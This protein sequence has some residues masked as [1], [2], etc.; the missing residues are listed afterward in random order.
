MLLSISKQP[1]ISKYSQLCHLT[2]FSFAQVFPLISKNCSDD[3]QWELLYTSL[4]LMPLGLLKCVIPWY[5]AHLSV[6][7]SRS[8]LHF[9][10]Q[11][12]DNFANTSF[13]SLLLEWFHIGYS[14]KSSGDI[15][16]DLQKIFKSRC[17]FLCE[18][19]KETAGCSSLHPN[20]QPCGESKSSKTELIP[21]NKGKKL[22]S[23]TSSG[24][25]KAETYETLYASEI[26]LH[27]FF[28][29]TKRLLLP[30]PKLPGGESSAT[31]ITDEPKPMDLIFF[32]HKALKKDFECLVSG[33]ARLVENIMFLMEF[34]KRFHLLWLRYQFHSDTEDEIAF[35]ALEAKGKVQN[36]SYSYTM[37][38][39]LEVKHFHEISLILDKMSKLHIS[40]SSA[41]S[42]M[43]AQIMVKYNK[44][45][46]K[47]HHM[48]KSMHKLLSDHIHHEE[49]E[50]WPLFRECFSIQEQEKI[51]GLMLGKA[52]AET[53][54]D[55]IP[56]LI[57]SL[58]PEEQHAMMSL[59]RKVTKNTMFDEWLGEWW[60]GH[61]IAHVAEE[62]NT[63]C[64]SDP[65]EIISKYLST[66]ALEE[67]GNI[68][69]DKGIKLD[70][71]GTNVDIL[72]KVQIG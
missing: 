25:H 53:L 30:F 64:T 15:G 68:L 3:T 10:N 8:F 18:Q 56:W 39:K 59:L 46:V 58:T 70:C 24:P 66:D 61:D 34:S 5:A 1:T 51:L 42:F 31:S 12:G 9:I 4:R 32:F 36:I 7:E 13:P 43:Q 65:L 47:L 45:C 71:F 23:Y 20:K 72:G 48:C 14:G 52:R 55:M 35:P 22:F 19:I 37:D 16:K 21:T 29:G 54:Q 38:H 57:G 50:L 67:Q 44:L 11:M 33:S 60:E 6:D 49:I 2:C 63:L 41:D 26:N 27:V 17:S 28:P 40:V 69:C 62:P